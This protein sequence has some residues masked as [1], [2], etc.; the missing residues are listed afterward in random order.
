MDLIDSISKIK[1]V[2]SQR[3]RIF[4]E[5]GIQCIKDILYYF[6]RRYL[7]RTIL[8]SISD[9]KKGNN[10]TLIAQVETFGEKRIRRGKMFQVIVS[11]GTGLLTLNWFNGV[12]YVKNQFKVGDKIAINGKVEWYNGFSITHPE[13]ERLMDDEDPIQT[14]AV[15]PVYPLTQDLRT[16]G[17]NQRSIRKILKNILSELETI[18]EIMPES[19][20]R[21][22]DLISLDQALRNIHFS[23]DLTE[24]RSAT[25]R[26]KFD[27]HFFLQMFLALRKKTTLALSSKRLIDVGPY[28]RPISETLDFEL[29]KAQKKV[30]QDVHLDMKNNHPMNRLVQGD[31]GCGKTIVAI[32]ISSIAVGNNVQVA[33]MAPTEILARQHFHTFKEQLNKVNITCALLIGKMRKGD[34]DKVISGLRMGKISIV[35]GTHALIQNDV[36]FHELGLVIIDEQHRFGVNQRSSLLEKGENP[37][38]MAMTATPIPRT[39]AITYHGDM[40]ISIIDELPLNRI[41]II[42][43]I[44]DPQ[45]LNKVYKF[46]RDEVSKGRQCIVVYPLVEESEKLD[47]SAAV[48]AYDE[49]SKIQFS[50]LNVGLVHGK[51]KAEEKDDIIKNFENNKIH[52]LVSTTVIEVGIDIPNA[53]VMLIEHA[54]RFGLTQLHQLRGRVGRGINKSYCILVRRNITDTSKNRLSV[55]EKTNDGFV[56]AD[57]DLK[58]RGPGE[59]FGLR[60][61]G[62]FQFKIADMVQDGSLLRQARLSAFDLIVQ[63]QKLT[64]DSNKK[65]REWFI[66]DYDQYLDTIKLSR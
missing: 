62:F 54:E 36:V 17:L 7:D 13:F 48:E 8:S 57:E 41:P 34:R 16:A 51:M 3:T 12:R 28:F 2:G 64:N 26:L 29:T 10:V 46:M 9:L 32:L 21:E 63:D 65:L 59:F 24:L 25:K 5:F 45:R 37:H 50:N 43:K 11:D 4:N 40:D 66:S 55:M 60:Q 30:I 1:G 22:N 31:V 42:T 56:I 6:P 47:L 52:I 27:E 39:L 33:I 61:S 20:L 49:L 44:V 19:I 58:L 35:V 15:I 18:P 38:S 14:G 53:T 23:N